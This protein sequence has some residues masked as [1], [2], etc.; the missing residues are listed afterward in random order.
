M[1]TLLNIIWLVFAGMWLALA[2]VIAGII[3]CICIITIPFGLASFRI[4]HYALWPFG[5]TIIR[6]PGASGAART[7]STV[8]NILWVVVAGWWLALGHIISGVIL[9]L[10]I[11]GIPFAVANFKMVPVSLTPLGREIVRTKSITTAGPRAMP[12]VAAW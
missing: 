8:G 5:R 4:A 1:K 3:S 11:V 9:C 2:Y 10:T 6:T 12:V 7:M